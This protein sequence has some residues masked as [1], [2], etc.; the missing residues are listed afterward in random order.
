MLQS[1][2]AALIDLATIITSVDQNT[3]PPTNQTYFEIS[4]AWKRTKSY[5]DRVLGVYFEV[6]AHMYQEQRQITVAPLDSKASSQLTPFGNNRISGDIGNLSG[7][8][9]SIHRLIKGSFM[10]LD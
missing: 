9:V 6:L 8:T 7:V 2:I 4:N 1:S 5:R 3:A 10:M